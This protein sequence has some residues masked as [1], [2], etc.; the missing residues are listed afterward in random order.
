[1]S[2]LNV[3]VAFEQTEDLETAENL[4]KSILK[5]RFMQ[6][7]NRYHDMYLNVVIETLALE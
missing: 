3:Y 2:N 7:Q 4:S 1:M 6:I 5:L